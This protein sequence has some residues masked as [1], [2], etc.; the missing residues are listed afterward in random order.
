ME[1][2]FTFARAP[3]P[4][5]YL[6]RQPT[7]LHPLL[8]VAAVSLTVLSL[9]GIGAITGLIP[10]A[11][12]QPEAAGE[13]I[14]AEAVGTPASH[15]AG[16]EKG[17]SSQSSG[18]SSGQGGATPAKAK[19]ACASCGVVETV[20]TVQLEGNASGIGAVAGGVTG[21]LVGNQFGRG[22]GNTAMTLIGAAGGAYA[23]N[24]IEKNMN[25]QT[26]YRITVRMDDGA[27]RTISQSHVPSVAA[28]DK[29]RVINGNVSA[30][31]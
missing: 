8:K 19:A 28:G 21:A 1:P 5:H 10:T 27:Y 12:S 2:T 11:S 22:G 18:K 15:R 23:G 17:A 7:T 29:V 24:S 3:L 14:A 16:A 30:I 6:S 13:A 9:L 20:R 25:R 31:P 26:A 4:R